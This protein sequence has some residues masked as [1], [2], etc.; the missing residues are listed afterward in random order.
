MKKKKILV[1]IIICISA[2]AI[3]AAIVIS[4][5]NSVRNDPIDNLSII[6]IR[7]E[8]DIEKE[9]GDIISVGKN[10][11]YK[12]HEDENI[13]KSPYSIETESGRVIVYVTLTKNDEEWKA[14]SL[15]VIEVIPND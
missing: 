1:L 9:Y 15:E 7:H 5:F 13:I 3:L 10:L 6:Y 4:L 11:L 2:Y 14:T 12:T 8:S